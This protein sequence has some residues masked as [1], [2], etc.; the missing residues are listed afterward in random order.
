M[1][2]QIKDMHMSL[3]VCVPWAV[4]REGQ[5]LP[6]SQKW[7]IGSAP[8]NKLGKEEVSNNHPFNFWSYHAGIEESNHDVPL[9]LLREL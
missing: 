2:I 4:M 3:W 5:L 7:R 6:G 8:A 9:D 1:L